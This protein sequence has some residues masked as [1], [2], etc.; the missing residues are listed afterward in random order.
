MEAIETVLLAVRAAIRQPAPTLRAM[1]AFIR[2]CRRRYPIDPAFGFGFAE[3]PYQPDDENA[4][5]IRTAK[6][7]AVIRR[8]CPAASGTTCSMAVP[9]DRRPGQRDGASAAPGQEEEQSTIFSASTGL[10][11]GKGHFVNLIGA[12][13]DGYRARD[14]LA[15]RLRG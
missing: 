13:C 11:L 12:L 8:G 2:W 3:V 7:L 1:K 5:T 4:V 15:V 14:A 6:K 10:S 9:R